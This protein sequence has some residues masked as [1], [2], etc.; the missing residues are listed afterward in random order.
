MFSFVALAIESFVFV[1]LLK[2]KSTILWM[3]VFPMTY[4]FFQW[5]LVKKIYSKKLL[6]LYMRRMS[7]LMFVSQYLFIILFSNYV[8]NLFLF[9]TVTMSCCIFSY[10]II[11]LSEIKVFKYLRYLY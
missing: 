9:V 6:G 5:L 7:T 3:S 11:R 1:F 8:N 2:T 10:V 4:Y